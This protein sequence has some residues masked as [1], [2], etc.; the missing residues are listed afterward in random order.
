M[1]ASEAVTPEPCTGEDTNVQSPTQP[2]CEAG[3]VAGVAAV[4]PILRGTHIGEGLKLSHR[5]RHR[6]RNLVGPTER[7]TV[8]HRAVHASSHDPASLTSRSPPFA[9]PGSRIVARRGSSGGH[10]GSS[11]RRSR[12]RATLDVMARKSGNRNRVMDRRLWDGQGVEWQ[13]GDVG[14]SLGRIERL[15]ATADRV[16]LHQFSGPPMRWMTGEEARSWWPTIRPYIQLPDG[17]L[18]PAPCDEA[19]DEPWLT[20]RAELWERSGAALLGFEG[21]C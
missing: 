17:D 5:H 15:L 8:T 14:L 19:A 13:R 4:V 9:R 10:D 7:V 2:V 12:S 20:Y 1:A 3:A 16:V 6:A 21:F 18:L 11:I